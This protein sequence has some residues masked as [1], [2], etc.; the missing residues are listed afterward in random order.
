LKTYAANFN[1]LLAQS[2]DEESNFVQEFL[3]SGVAV[4]QCCLPY[5]LYRK[6][7]AANCAK[8]CASYSNMEEGSQVLALQSV[9]AL[10]ILYTPNAP[11]TPR[12]TS[13]FDFTIKVRI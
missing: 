7:L 12:D 5:G 10:L 2:L 1:K 13:L 11:G 4:A 8:I 3:V 9:R 6:K